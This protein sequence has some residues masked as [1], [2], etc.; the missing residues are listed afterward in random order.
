MLYDLETK[1]V[2]PLTVKDG[3]VEMSL[4]FAGSAVIFESDEPY[5]FAE[6]STAN[7]IDLSGEWKVVSMTDN[8]LTI[9]MAKL[10][11][12]GVNY[13]EKTYIPALFNALIKK[14]YLGKIYLKYE[15]TVKDI[16]QNTKKRVTQKVT[17]FSFTSFLLLQ[18]K[19]SYT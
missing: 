8:S 5:A 12:D 14:Q 2:K 17:L 10:S 6:V 16:P 11:Y 9:D 15:F 19:D 7:D 3:K 18:L 13:G 4:D 1:Q